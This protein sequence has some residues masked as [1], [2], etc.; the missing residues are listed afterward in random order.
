MAMQFPALRADRAK[1]RCRRTLSAPLTALG[2]APF[3]SADSILMRLAEAY[4][5][6]AEEKKAEN[7]SESTK[8]AM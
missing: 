7:S 2:R 3:Y 6:R 1:S 4:D 5:I 8:A